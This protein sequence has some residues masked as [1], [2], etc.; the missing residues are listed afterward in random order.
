MEDIRRPGPFRSFIVACNE[1]VFPADDVKH[2]RGFGITLDHVL[3]RL[4]ESY[5]Q[6]L[7]SV[8]SR[9]ENP[10]SLYDSHEDL[11]VWEGRRLRAVVQ[12]GAGEIRVTR[13]D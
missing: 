2:Y 6:T 13:F 12:P 3:D 9:G 10:E 4:Q 8:T 5:Q 7:A 1:V 11:T